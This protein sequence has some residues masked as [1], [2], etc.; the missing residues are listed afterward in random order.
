MSAH[1]ETAA[2]PFDI[3]VHV[4]ASHIHDGTSRPSP[5]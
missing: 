2:D 1:S 4:A 3:D 5:G